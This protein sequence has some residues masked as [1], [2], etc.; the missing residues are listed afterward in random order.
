MLP[1][2]RKREK[3]QLKMEGQEDTVSSNELLDEQNEEE[4]DEEVMTSLS[5][6]PEWN[7]SKEDQYSFQFL[8]MECAP[9]KPNQISLSGISLQ[10]DE[11]NNAQI[12]AFIRSSLKK[13]I[14][15]KETTL[16]LLDKDDKVLGRKK[17]DLSEVGEIPPESSR[18]W[19]FIF[20]EKDLFT[21][22][23][24]SED[25]KLAFQLKPS[26]RKHTLELEDSWEKSLASKDKEK[27]KE[28]V[29]KLTPP[30]QGEVNFMG[31]KADQKENGNLHV[32]ILIRNG[33]NRNIK[34]EQIP[35]QIKDAN[36][37]VVA[38]GGFKLD[39]FEVKANTS[40]P[41]TFIFPKE[42]V[43]HDNPDLSKW[44]AEPIRKA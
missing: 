5:F 8:N 42:L 29:D 21:T 28:M 12:T 24:P 14:K 32:T 22:E 1:F 9:L 17:M 25:W 6:H 16:V 18:P 19:T 33:N 30:K 20:T 23:L 4:G 26:S 31:L 34:L 41:W 35:L 2:F 43:Q 38:K 27:L 36:G 3:D 15:L 40:K 37:T 44:K 7:V 10:M 11:K 39:D 13:T